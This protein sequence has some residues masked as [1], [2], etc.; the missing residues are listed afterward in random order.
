M[1][2]TV[3]TAVVI[4]VITAVVIYV[5]KKVVHAWQKSAEIDIE[6]PVCPSCRGGEEPGCGTCGSKGRQH[7]KESRREKF[8]KLLKAY[9]IE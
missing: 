7:T 3:I 5:P 4:A 9:L 1:I 8:R 2:K 6:T